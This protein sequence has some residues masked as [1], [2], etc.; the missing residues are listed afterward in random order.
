MESDFCKTLKKSFTTKMVNLVILFKTF[1][2]CKIL[3]VRSYFKVNPDKK[4]LVFVKKKLLVLC[5]RNQHPL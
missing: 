2:S 5:L 4:Y 3:V 1:V